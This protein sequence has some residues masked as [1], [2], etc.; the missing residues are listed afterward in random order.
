VLATLQVTAHRPVITERTTDP[1]R[2]LNEQGCCDSRC[3]AAAVE[4]PCFLWR[5]QFREPA[6]A[7][8]DIQRPE[9][10]PHAGGTDD[11]VSGEPTS[12]LRDLVS[13]QRRDRS[14]GDV[15]EHQRF[16]PRDWT[17]VNEHASQARE[18]LTVRASLAFEPLL[19]RLDGSGIGAH[20]GPSTG[21]GDALAYRHARRAHGVVRPIELPSAVVPY[22]NG[23]T[24]T[25]VSSSSIFMVG[26]VT[27]VLLRGL[28]ARDAGSL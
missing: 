21:N 22:S 18:L 24:V 12:Y 3:P 4:L 7:W 6:I 27:E 8:I 25:P 16:R 17:R 26:L 9:Q 2:S 23:G 13:D 10:W 11:L 5:A 20:P 14:F 19:I 28:A 15:D 1:A